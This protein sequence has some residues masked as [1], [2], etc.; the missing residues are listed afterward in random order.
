M[1]DLGNNDKKCVTLTHIDATT[2]VRYSNYT[3]KTDK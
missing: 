2:K 1:N 3:F